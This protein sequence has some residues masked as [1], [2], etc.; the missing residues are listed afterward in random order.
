MDESVMRPGEAN[1]KRCRRKDRVVRYNV[2][3]EPG[4]DGTK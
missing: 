1:P 4:F 2:L 3:A